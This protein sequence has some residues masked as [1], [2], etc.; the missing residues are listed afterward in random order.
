VYIFFVPWALLSGM[1]VQWLWESLGAAW[2]PRASSTL[3]AGLLASCLLIF[4]LYAYWLFVYHQ[5]EI[6]RTWEQNRPKGYWTAYS[7]P[8]DQSLFGF[9]IRSGWKA[10]GVLY[11]RGQ[12]DGAYTTNSV[13][14]WVSDWYTRGA[15]RCLRD[16]RYQFVADHLSRRDQQRRQ[17]LLAEL[18]QH[19]GQRF[20]VLV[21]NQPRMQIWEKGNE[22]AP[23]SELSIDEVAAEFDEHLS[24]PDFP[25]TA[26]VIEPP[27]QRPQKV[28]FGE[29]I[30]LEGYALD[31][32]SAA[33]GEGV[34]FTLYWRATGPVEIRYRVETQLRGED[35][36]LAG[37]A[38]GEPGCDAQPTDDWAV[39]E[40]IVDPHRLIV[41]PDTP[42]GAYRIYIS[43][44][45]HETG[46][47]LA[48]ADGVEVALGALEVT[49]S[50][51][52]T[53][54]PRPG[55]D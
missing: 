32:S 10:A 38:A 20:A 18:P 53:P 28:Q 12:L 14:A 33:A 45:G 50:T 30:W 48:S 49:A 1:V 24:G 55:Q 21:H 35:G 6:F 46:D 54:K 8:D 36:W 2:T 51:A 13:D 42:P 3:V 52:L 16:H 17:Q 25:L 4:G 44:T 19:Y 23:V 47:R 40:L 15:D 34:L 7:L 29:H 37:N 27:I 43:L 41:A 9:P 5:V 31:R 11:A 26:P 22:D 39:G